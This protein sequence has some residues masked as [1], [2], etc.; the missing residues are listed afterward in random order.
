MPLYYYGMSKQPV[1]RKEIEKEFIN[2]LKAMKLR[3]T[4]R[5]SISRTK[6]KIRTSILNNENEV[7]NIQ[8]L[9]GIEIGFTSFL[10]CFCT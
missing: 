10:S 5:Q 8:K 3:S 7:G 4:K 2:L 1:N 6:P 9:K